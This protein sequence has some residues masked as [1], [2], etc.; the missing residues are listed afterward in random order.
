M[1]TSPTPRPFQQLR[2]ELSA[3]F[4]ERREVIDGALCAVLAGEHVFLLGPPGT[5][6]SAL[7]RAVA[8]AFD[9]PYFE[10][11]LTKF[12]TPEELFGPI[13]LKALEAD[14][15]ARL[16]VGMLP[17]AH[18]AF[19]D[20][21]FKSNSAILN[22]LLA[23][24]NERVFH[25]DGGAQAC[26]LITLFG[27]SNELP[28]GREL[29]ATF[30]RFLLRYD[31]QYLLRASS[32]RSIFRAGEPRVTSSFSVADLDAARQ[33]V[34]AVELTDS[35][36]EKLIE[37]RDLCRSEGV[38]ASDRR[39]KKMLSVVKANAWL[40]GEATTNTEDLLILSH[41]LWRDPKDKSKIAQ[42]VGQIA[43]PI[44]SQANLILDAARDTAARVAGT[45][46]DRKAYVAQAAQALEELQAQKT[47]LADLAK[48]AGPRARSTLADVQQEIQLLHAELSR[49]VASTMG[50]GPAR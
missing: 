3:A 31:V 32:L 18:L 26:P 21:I 27:A 48:E 38:V 10:R 15:Y 25:N 23:I 39:W 19:I 34:A 33:A 42:L 29:E 49:S 9:A 37:I 41:T 28:E 17:S 35:T 11:L 13:S 7:V 6:K 44:T 24:M 45:K 8:R 47:K 36:V 40:A 22:A 4:P 50:L 1:S 16:T 46:A 2:E 5:A 14:R 12:S 20:E 30:D 43:D